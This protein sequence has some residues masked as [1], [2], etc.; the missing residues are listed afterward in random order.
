MRTRIGRQLAI[1]WSAGTI[2]SALGLAASFVFDLPTG[3]TMVCMFGGALALAGLL[4]PFL[5]GD[6]GLA[7]GARHG[8]CAGVRRGC[9]QARRCC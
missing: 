4:Y 6:M 7:R 2:T 8:P 3:A 9:S 1:G 5:C